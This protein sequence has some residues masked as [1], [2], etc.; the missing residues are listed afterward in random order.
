M[1]WPALVAS[2]FALAA[3]PV[4]AQTTPAEKAWSFSA[5]D[6]TY[7]VPDDRNYTQPTLAADRGWLHLAARYNYED[8]ETGSIWF[9]CN[10]GGGGKLQWGFTPMLG[11]VVG[12]TA[13]VA[14]GWLFTLSYWRLDLSLES[15]YVIDA[16]DTTES[17]FYN[18]SE[19][20]VSP[21][22]WLRV[23]VVVQRTRAYKTDRDVQRGFLVGFTY[24]MA[25][26]TTYVFNPDETKP[27]VVLGV[28]VNF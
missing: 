8:F 17:F 22:D 12:T 7:I 28:T 11:G 18:W 16:R 4:W 9:G 10:F 13:G 24:R 27:I 15:E 3:S 23:G 19:L 21:M 6:Y 25:D 14:P 5:S 20:G 26:F 2:V 1:R